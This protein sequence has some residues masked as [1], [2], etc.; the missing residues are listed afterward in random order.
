VREGGGEDEEFRSAYREDI[1]LYKICGREGSVILSWSPVNT[2][3]EKQ[4]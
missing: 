4:I 3:G 2:S 1:H